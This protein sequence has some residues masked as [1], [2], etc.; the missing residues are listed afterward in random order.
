MTLHYP[1]WFRLV[2]VRGYYSA[3]AIRER[4]SWER[5]SAN[6]LCKLAEAECGAFEQ[7]V[8]AEKERLAALTGAMKEN[9]PLDF[10]KQSIDLA[11]LIERDRN[12]A[13]DR[14]RCASSGLMHI[15]GD[16]YIRWLE[17]NE[18]KGDEALPEEAGD[19]IE[20]INWTRNAIAFL[21]EFEQRDQGFTI[22]VSLRDV[23]GDGKWGDWKTGGYRE[24][25][26]ALDPSVFSEYRY[27]RLR[28]ISA[29]VV[30]DRQEYYPWRVIIK[31]PRRQRAQ[32]SGGLAD[33]FVDLP[34][35]SQ[36][37]LGRVDTQNSYRMPD[38]SGMMS[39][40]NLCP[41]SH[42]ALPWASVE[43]WSI[44][45]ER[46]QRSL[47]NGVVDDLRLELVVAGLPA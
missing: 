38:V 37:S 22:C 16:A 25:S 36:V 45:A 26:F 35:N 6:A 15:Y 33:K 7:R 18:F 47:D 44:R 4:A 10:S 20:I 3:E 1:V 30:S 28:G 14:L 9:G 2:R 27:V 40:Y 43:A 39:L 21:S 8:T 24:I 46:S 41:G 5:T 17:K 23:L 12:D 11:R 13:F 42:R 29:V 19:P 31:P 34:L 32:T